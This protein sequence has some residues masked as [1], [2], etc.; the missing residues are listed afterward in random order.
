MNSQFFKMLCW[1]QKKRGNNKDLNNFNKDQ[2]V[3]ASIFITSGLVRCSWYACP[4]WDNKRNGEGSVMEV[5]DSLMH[6][7]SECKPIYP[8][9]T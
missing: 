9:P 7:E 8:N 1:K 2:I 3:M 5:Q 6:V 4:K